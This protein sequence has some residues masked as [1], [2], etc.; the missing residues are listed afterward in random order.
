MEVVTGKGEDR[1]NCG[2][3]VIYKRKINKNNNKRKKNNEKSK[4][5]GEFFMML[6]MYLF[7]L[8][9][10]FQHS[11]QEPLTHRCTNIRHEE[12]HF[13][14]LIWVV[15]LALQTILIVHVVLGYLSGLENG[16]LLLKMPH[17]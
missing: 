6:N 10:P 11:P 9:I 1:G 8:R 3:N 7:C 16:L 4:L 15:Q 17:N 14:D 13:E 2:R 12:P 5:T